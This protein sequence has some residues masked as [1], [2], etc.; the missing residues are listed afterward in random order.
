LTL[1]G[2]PI[3]SEGRSYLV[4]RELELDG[5]GALK[6]LVTDYLQQAALLDGVPMATLGF[7]LVD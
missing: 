4:E 5:Y 1:E 2:F 7:S 3:S 6:A